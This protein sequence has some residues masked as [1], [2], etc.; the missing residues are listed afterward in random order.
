MKVVGR[1][2]AACVRDDYCAKVFDGAYACLYVGRTLAFRFKP[3]V[4]V[5]NVSL[6]YIL[7]ARSVNNFDDYVIRVN[8]G[9]YVISI[10]DT[11]N[12]VR[13][14][15]FGMAENNK[16]ALLVCSL[17]DGTIG[18]GGWLS[19]WQYRR[20]LVV[21]LWYDWYVDL[22]DIVVG[23]PIASSMFPG[24][25]SDF[26]DLRV[27]GDDGTTL[28]DFYYVNGVFRIKIP[29]AKLGS[30]V[31]MRI[32]W[33][34]ANASNVQNPNLTVNVW[35]GD[36]NFYVGGINTSDAVY[37]LRTYMNSFGSMRKYYM[38]TQPKGGVSDSVFLRY[39]FYMDRFI[40]YYIAEDVVTER[41]FTGDLIMDGMAALV[42][43]D[44]REK[45]AVENLLGLK[46]VNDKLLWGWSKEIEEAI[47]TGAKLILVRKG[48]G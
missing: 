4:N 8:G 20:L 32:Y 10:T 25:Q 17:K 38:L 48:R 2:S 27:T 46:Y 1:N 24:A 18:A 42:L 30:V 12:V 16:W 44:Y 36:R 45:G 23:I 22:D 29:K 41:I 43:F 9:R 34:N 40:S 26:R 35:D 11:D 47:N 37:E 5:E 39:G 28:Y 13:E 19:G 7:R 15:W 31:V 33:G 6:D 21:N 14:F 3:T